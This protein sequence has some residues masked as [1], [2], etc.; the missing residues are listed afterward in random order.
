MEKSIELG[1]AVLSTAAVNLEL[2]LRTLITISPQQQCTDFGRQDPNSLLEYLA[3]GGVWVGRGSELY[4]E[5]QISSERRPVSY[6]QLEQLSEAIL[7]APVSITRSST[8][9]VTN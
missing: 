8:N 3:N 5:L 4:I 7:I 9:L 6:E 2:W 1:R